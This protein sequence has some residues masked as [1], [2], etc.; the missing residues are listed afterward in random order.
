VSFIVAEE[1]VEQA[2]SALRC[3]IAEEVR[4]LQAR[5]ADAGAIR[6]APEV[7]GFREILG[8]DAPMVA[9]SD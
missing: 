9:E 6:S 8:K 5:F 2:N 4:A 3:E 7:I 1:Y